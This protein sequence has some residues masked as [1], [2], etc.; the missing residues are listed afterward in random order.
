MEPNNK[1]NGALIG[2]I[3]IILI[4]IVGGIYFYTTRV[5]QAP[6][7]PANNT[8]ASALRADLNALEAQMN[9]NT[10]SSNEEFMVNSYTVESY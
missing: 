6:S 5:S 4:L 3:I 10:H 2:S 1:S 9:T 8:E 7:L